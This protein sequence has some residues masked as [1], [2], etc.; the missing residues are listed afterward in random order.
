MPNY[1]TPDFRGTREHFRPCLWTLFSL[2]Y[3][4]L[5]ACRYIAYTLFENMCQRTGISK[6]KQEP[7]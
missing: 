4:S 2:S 5:P 3:V 6:K 1:M 7:L